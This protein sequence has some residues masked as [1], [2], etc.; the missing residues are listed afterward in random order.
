MRKLMI[1]LTVICVLGLGITWYTQKKESSNSSDF[2]AKT[3]LVSK[4]KQAMNLITEGRALEKQEK[5]DEALAKY[6]EVL[7]QFGQKESAD[8]EEPV[9]MALLSKASILNQQNKIDETLSALDTL[10]QRFS[11][12]EQQVTSAVVMQGYFIKAAIF[13]NSHDSKQAI[14]LSDEMLSRYGQ[15]DKV[16]ANK[17]ALS[18][19]LLLKGDALVKQTRYQEA[20]VV[21]DEIIKRF[22]GT[23]NEQIDSFVEAAFF[24]KANVLVKLEQ[25]EQAIGIFE[26]VIKW[27][28]KVQDDSMRQYIVHVSMLGKAEA[29]ARLNRVDAS[30]KLFDEVINTM[31][32]SQIAVLKDSVSSAQNSKG[33]SLLLLAKANW[34]NQ[35]VRQHYLNEAKQL[36]VQS[37]AAQ[38]SDSAPFAIGNLAYTHY[39]LKE[40]AEVEKKMKQALAGG[41]EELYIGTLEDIRI[42]SIPKEDAAFKTL[43]EQAWK[44]VRPQPESVVS[45]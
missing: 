27:S 28:V 42:H 44:E 39:L 13:A 24:S 1:G 32:K 22:T 45:K 5:H 18:G 19:V 6:E 2:L 12:S 26:D 35:S 36:F 10:I 31:S 38:E 25:F 15:N 21:F 8:L 16:D 43:V 37:A 30:M 4:Q 14:A 29:M 7:K 34:Q 41:G 40:D 33:Y 3:G 11:P 20:Q 17:I 23:K 9:A